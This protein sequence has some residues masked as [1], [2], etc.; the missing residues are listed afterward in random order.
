MTVF[1]STARRNAAQI[2]GTDISTAT[3]LDDALNTSGLNWG[4]EDI[5]ADGINI[6][7]EDG[8]ISTSIPGHRM[9]MRSDNQVTLGVVGQRYETVTNREAFALA[10]AAKS[11]GATFAHA[12]ELDHGRKSFLTMH[13][14]EAQVSVGGHDIIDFSLV[15]R[16]SHDGSGAITGEAMGTRL[17]CTNGM[18]APIEGVTQ[19]WSI[20]HTSGADNALE[21]AR[22]ALKHIMAYAKEFAAHAD[23]MINQKFS[24]RDF[25]QLVATVFP[26]PDEDLA[27]PRRINAWERRREELMDLFIEQDTQEEGRLTQWGAWNAIV[28]HNDWYRSANNGE[29]G[30]ALRNFNGD[31]SGVVNRS[32]RLLNA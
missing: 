12:G 21:E 2:L 29:E 23:N 17:V 31:V 8:I 7:T 14:P 24:E 6:L 27:T 13:L 9:L 16:T 30:R 5:P 10:D 3:T 19:R 4:I 11:L 1:A 26:Q 22:D 28:E 18:R 20:R 32:F 25:N 15:L